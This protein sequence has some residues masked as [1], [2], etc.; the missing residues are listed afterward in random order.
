MLRLPT[1]EDPWVYVFASVVFFLMLNWWYRSRKLDFRY[2]DAFVL[3]TGCD[4]GFGH[5][6][7][8]KFDKMGFNVFAG[9]LSSDKMDELSAKCSPRLC[10]FHLDVTS[11]ASVS[12]ALETVKGRLPPNRGLWAII[13]NAGVM[14]TLG[15][16]EWLKKQDYKQTLSVNMFG[17]VSVTKA[18]LPLVGRG[19]PGVERRL[20]TQKVWVRAQAISPPTGWTGVSLM[21]LRQASWLTYHVLYMAA[22]LM[23][24]H[25]RLLY[26]TL[27]KSY[28]GLNEDLKT[29]YGEKYTNGMYD[30]L[31][32]TRNG[33]WGKN[34]EEVVDVYVHAVTSRHPKTRYVVGLNGNLLFRPLWM[35]PTRLSAFLV[36]M[37]MPK[38]AGLG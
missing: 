26:K 6:A 10:P 13:N 28:E 16:V 1:F 5:I 12:K 30:L 4:T 35:L 8:M 17:A 19:G 33:V 21:R 15:A 7:A 9:C 11:D 24:R 32:L 27:E 18:F 20:P 14:G 2:Q 31:T 29:F 22:Y 36:G 25:A 34:L 3:I 37:G 38:P 23:I